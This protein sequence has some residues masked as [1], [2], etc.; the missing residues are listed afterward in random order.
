VFVGHY[1]VSFG[2]KKIEPSQGGSGPLELPGDRI[3]GGS[4]RA[5]RRNLDL[6]SRATGLPIR[7]C[8]FQRADARIPRAYTFLGPPPHPI[9]AFASTALIVY[10][11]FAIVIWWLQGIAKQLPKKLSARVVSCKPSLGK[12]VGRPVFTESPRRHRSKVGN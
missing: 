5:I 9:A 12:E 7:D 3:G 10:T 6:P 11:V 2:A 4:H 8:A 1:G